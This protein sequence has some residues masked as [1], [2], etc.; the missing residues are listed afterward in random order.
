MAL[1]AKQEAFCQEYMI[2]FNATQAALRSGYSKDSAGA[3]G[4]E[5]LLKPEIASRIEEL[6][7]ERS[8]KT[9]IT[10]DYILTGLKETA[11]RCLQRVPVMRWDYQAKEMV[12]VKD[13]EGKDV[14]EFDSNGANKAFELLGKHIGLFEKDNRQ[15]SAVI[16]VNLTEDET[17][18]PHEP[19]TPTDHE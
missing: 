4:S 9:N 19:D 8:K 1:N 11:E 5:N 18:E 13:D 16:N 10:A 17:A 2:D 15:K 14:W 7:L 3:I 6:R 12:Q